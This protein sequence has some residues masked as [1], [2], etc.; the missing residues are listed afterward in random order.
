MNTFDWI[1]CIVGAILIFDVCIITVLW[2]IH[3]DDE[4]N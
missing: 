2:F 1:A 4:V 3:K